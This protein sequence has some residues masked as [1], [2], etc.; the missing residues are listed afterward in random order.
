MSE[1]KVKLPNPKS[2]LMS[3]LGRLMKLKRKMKQKKPEFMRMDEWRFIRIAR[4][5]SW[6]RPKGLDNKI[7]KEIK[8]YPPRVKV[9]YR[10]PKDVRGLHPSGFIEV[11]VYRPQDLESLDP[12]KHAIRIAH[13]VGKKKRIEIIK[14][15]IKRGFKILNLRKEERE[16]LAELLKPEAA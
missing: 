14:E 5:D 3:K 4:K 1:I 15:A 6:R 13:T 12:S 10:T 9:G 16:M 11:L 7:R 8:G 2:E